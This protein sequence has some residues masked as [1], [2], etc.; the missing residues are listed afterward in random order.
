MYGRVRPRSVSQTRSASNQ[1]DRFG[2]V[3]RRGLTDPPENS[4]KFK[5]LATTR[6]THVYHSYVSLVEPKSL[7]KR[8]GAGVC[9]PMIGRDAVVGE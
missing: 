1:T 9:G 5:I 6:S 2:V 8:T 4:N 7:Q 3:P